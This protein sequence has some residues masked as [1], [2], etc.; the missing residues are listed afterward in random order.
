MTSPTCAFLRGALRRK[1]LTLCVLL[2]ASTPAFA[3]DDAMLR[4]R[5]VDFSTARPLAGVEITL[6]A[7]DGSRRTVRTDAAG[8]FAVG[9]LAEGLYDLTA[10]LEGFQRAAEQR[11]RAVPR[12]ATTIDFALQPLADEALQ[13]VLV[14]ARAVDV[15]PL[16][17]VGALRLDREAIRRS[18]GTAGDVFRALDILPGVAATGEFSQFAVRGN[19]Q[20]DNLILIDGLPFDK[21]VHFSQSLGEQDEIGGGGRFSIFAPD[22]IAS[23]EFQ[24]GGWRASQ[25]G[26]N[27][28][29]LQLDL[30]GGNP[31]TA[32]TR[33]QLDV[34]G[35]EVGYEGPSGLREDTTLFASARSL[36]FERVFE[37]IDNPDLGA[38]TLT[39]LI[40]KLVSEPSPE[41]RLE[42]LAIHTTEDFVRDVDNVLLSENFEDTTLARSNQDSSLFGLTWKWFPGERAQM[43]NQF[44]VRESDKLSARGEAFPDLA[45]PGATAAQVPARPDI[46]TLTEAEREIGWRLDFNDVLESGDGYSLGARVTRTELDFETR[47]A[48][49]WTRFE[50]DRDD[51]RPNPAQRFIVLTPQR[52]DSRFDQAG[53]DA[54]LYADYT[55]KAGQVSVT[56]GLR[57]DYI[58]FSRESLLSP[59]LAVNWQVSPKLRIWSGGGVYYQNPSFLSL[60][61]DPANSRL[62]AER[63]TQIAVG[64]QREIGNDWRLSVETYLQALD[65]LV[66]TTDRTDGRA[67]NRGEG[68]NSGIDVALTRRFGDTWWGSASYSWLRAKRD[69][70]L[71]AGEFDA[72]QHRPHVL[73]IFGG[74]EPSTRWAFSAKWK[75]ASG[76]PRDPFVV[77]ADVLG[78]AGPRRFS[79]EFIADNT[80]RF[81]AF[82]TL[83]VRVDYRR[84]LGPVN[85]VGF[86]DV[87]NVYG[88]AIV[89]AREW[90]E[91]RGV[92]TGDGL[93]VLP[94]IGVKFE[95][96]WNR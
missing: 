53:T 93:S 33:A 52:L 59:R 1:L 43:R 18:P 25:G 29:L 72:D 81:P 8:E 61:A 75:Y 14:T 69:E 63:S 17:S 48:G 7:R 55:W 71:G 77:Y 5:V 41:H 31:A 9:D 66:V 86:I 23:A 47:L 50:Y 24:P 64:V 80:D 19:G 87:I 45:P 12:A 2:A 82:H 16:A 88:R 49:N 38:P 91:R 68:S 95:Y 3:A 62:G 89:D 15:D 10:T 40:A 85:L 84:R 60:G 73:T 67:S 90:D 74:W 54:T 46:L 28:S 35:L 13:E 92:E 34:A 79:R 39:D 32:T 78:P 57:Y 37:A 21:V 22:S 83:N 51:F 26:R 65:R 76:R 70:R 44:Y 58:D 36:D 11:V 56:P 20:R 27:G 42:L 6:A 96:V 30:V 4:G 94:T